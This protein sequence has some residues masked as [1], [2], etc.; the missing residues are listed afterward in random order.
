MAHVER[1]AD[2]VPLGARGFSLAGTV[3]LVAGA[4]TVSSAAAIWTEDFDP[5]VRVSDVASS[6]DIT[7]KLSIPPSFDDPSRRVPRPACLP[8]SPR[9]P[10][11]VPCLRNSRFKFREAKDRLAENCG[12]K[13]GGQLSAKTYSALRRQTRPKPSSVAAVPLPRPRPVEANQEPRNDIS[14]ARAEAPGV[15]AQVP[16]ARADNRTLLEKFSDLLPGRLRLPRL[17]PM[18][19]CL[20]RSRT[21]PRLATTA[22]PPS[23]ISRRA[24]FTCRMD[25]N[26]KPIPATAA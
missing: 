15:R 13:A 4:L 20:A 26:S 9:V 6:K 22:L 25:Q 2:R 23:M 1:K 11:F 18:A 5:A 12:L 24:P 14:M 19:A 17:L 3:A 7:P 16:T 21:S 10:S 8:D